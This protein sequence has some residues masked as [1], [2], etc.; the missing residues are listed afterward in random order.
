MMVNV[1]EVSDGYHTF[2]ELYETRHTLWIV[3]AKMLKMLGGH[4]YK[5]RHYEGWFV[6]GVD[7][8]G[9]MSFHLPESLWDLCDFAD[10]DER[11]R[12]VF[13][14]H[15]LKIVLERLRKIA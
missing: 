11:T 12:P 3:T 6:L 8:N 13:D 15:D 5:Y 10:D 7:L 4:V 14:G 9:Q 1:E 2:A